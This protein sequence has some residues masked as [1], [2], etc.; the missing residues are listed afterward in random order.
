MKALTTGVTM[1]PIC[2]REIAYETRMK[3]AESAI[4]DYGKAFLYRVSSRLVLSER[5]C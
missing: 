3:T 5:F 1:K 4:K 2:R